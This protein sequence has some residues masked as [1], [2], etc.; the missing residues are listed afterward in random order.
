M[1]AQLSRLSCDLFLH[2]GL[3]SPLFSLSKHRFPL[4]GL[5]QRAL[6]SSLE[7]RSSFPTRMLLEVG[8]VH[9]TLQNMIK[10]LLLR[11]PEPLIWPAPMNKWIYRIDA[12][13]FL[14]M[15]IYAD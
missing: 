10:I 2:A 1:D 13:E 12:D 14:L 6:D 11:L 7:K 5:A 15:L 3:N 4:L 9:N 8:L